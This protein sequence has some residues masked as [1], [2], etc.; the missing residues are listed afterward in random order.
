[1][2]MRE[3]NSISQNRKELAKRWNVI[4]RVTFKQ[5]KQINIHT[6]M[7]LSQSDIVC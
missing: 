7:V 4:Q 3:N 1:M 6:W 2:L 5:K